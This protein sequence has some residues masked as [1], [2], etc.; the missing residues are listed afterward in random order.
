MPLPDPVRN[1]AAERGADYAP[2]LG[3]A[4]LYRRAVRV[5]DAAGLAASVLSS[6]QAGPL[7]IARAERELRRAHA[8]LGFLDG[9]SRD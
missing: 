2:R 6:P 5:R 1:F 9:G 8:M 7:E 3:R 4:E